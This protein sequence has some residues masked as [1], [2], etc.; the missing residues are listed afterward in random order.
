MF[1]ETFKN[2]FETAFKKTHTNS[3]NFNGSCQLFKKRV[4][5]SRWQ[6]YEEIS[7]NFLLKP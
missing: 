3:A 6:A 2:E 1:D 4:P 5:E 7:E